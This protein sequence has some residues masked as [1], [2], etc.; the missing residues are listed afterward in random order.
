M[1]AHDV[2]ERR[3]AAAQHLRRHENRIRRARQLEHDV[4]VGAELAI[5]LDENTARRNIEHA[6][7]GAVFQTRA[8]QPAD[9]VR[10]ETQMT[11]AL[12]IFI[13]FDDRI[14]ET[15][16]LQVRRLQ[17]RN[18]HFRE[19]LGIRLSNSRATAFHPR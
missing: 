8:S 1:I 11:A 13:A 5:G 14:G 16:D 9:I 12:R 7:V 15:D 4:G 19:L 2:G 17:L 10:A 18:G 6:H 3:H